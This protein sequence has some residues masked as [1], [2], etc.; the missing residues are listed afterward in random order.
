MSG[1]VA[2]A[3]VGISV[4]ALTGGEV[5]AQAAPAATP[6]AAAAQSPAD[7][8]IADVI[9]TAQR[10]SERLQS[11]PVA[12]TALTAQ[13]LDR[14]GIA[15]T[16]DLQVVTPGLVYSTAISVPTPFIRGVGSRDNTAANESG[17]AT[18]LDGIYYAGMPAGLLALPNIERIEVLKGPQGTLFGRNANGGLIQIITRDPPRE[19]SGTVKLSYAN[20]DTITASGYLGG[21]VTETLRA[22]LSV[23]Y[24]DQ[25]DGWGRN[26]VSGV[27]INLAKD[28]ALRGKA[29]WEPAVGTRVVLAAD[30]DHR[31]SD[32]GSAVNILA[33][34]FAADGRCGGPFP[35]GYPACAPR[36]PRPCGGRSMTANRTST[37][38]TARTGRK[39]RA[40]SRAESA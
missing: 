27:Q 4:I 12:V 2:K 18:Y 9:V 16:S 35:V 33:G 7:V 8:G 5:L 15:Q 17:V 39:R 3:L 34:T 6:D 1:F 30:Y 11:V 38:S 24:T 23:Y 26:L 36:P 28:I 20:Y 21:P 25:R 40:P 37:A 14:A 10:R 19:L 13:A 29:L 32:I 31:R 22:D